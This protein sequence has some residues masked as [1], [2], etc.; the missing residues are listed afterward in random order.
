M[1][2]LFVCLVLGALAWLSNGAEPSAGPLVYLGLLVAVPALA[3]QLAPVHRQF[4]HVGA[5]VAGLLLGWT[6]LVSEYALESIKPYLNVAAVWVGMHLGASLPVSLLH[7]RRLLLALLAACAC[8]VILC[9]T[10]LTLL[11]SLPAGT[12]LWLALLSPI[13][14]P[15]FVQISRPDRKQAVWLSVLLTSM[16][17][18]MWL[19]FASPS[20]LWPHGGSSVALMLLIWV[21][22]MEALHRASEVVRSEPGHFLL[23]GAAALVLSIAASRSGVP[24]LYLGLASGLLLAVRTRR[25]PQ[26]ISVTAPVAAM[27][28]PFVL[29]AF[30]GRLPVALLLDSL[31]ALWPM[32]A[33]YTGCLTGGKLAGILLAGRLTPIPLRDWILTLPQGLPA[34]I[35]ALSVL[36][37]HAM[38]LGLDPTVLVAALLGLCGVGLSLVTWPLQVLAIRRSTVKG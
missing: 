20:G 17:L 24:A 5:L 18:A 28:V 16:G 38:P 37:S 30:A 31:P 21:M 32:L 12:A 4:A 7:D 36:P 8:P 22:G 34:G 10:G 27:L 29:A 23:N 11:L 6:G 9:F 25:P 19:L 2:S 13:S 1:R 14:A 26:C 35:L 33:V 15:L 3:S